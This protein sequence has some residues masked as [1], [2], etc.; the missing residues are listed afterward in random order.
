MACIDL[1]DEFLLET[2]K[3]T[4]HKGIRDECFVLFLKR[5]CD[6][7]EGKGWEW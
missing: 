1:V 2:G 4:S 7:D 3:D 5:R 6:D